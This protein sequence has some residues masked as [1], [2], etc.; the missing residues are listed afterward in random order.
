M[1]ASHSFSDIPREIPE[2]QEIINFT[3]SHF[4]KETSFFL[5]MDIPD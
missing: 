1:E 3:D 5:Q 2:T 4:G